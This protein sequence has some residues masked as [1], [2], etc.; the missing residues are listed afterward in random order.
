MV[1]ELRRG[2][3]QHG[4]VLANGGVLTY[5]HALC[6]STRPR[7]DGSPYPDKN[8]LARYV[9]DIP[10]PIITAEAEGEA[11]IE[12]NPTSNLSALCKDYTDLDRADLYSR[13]QP[14]RHSFKRVRRGPAD[15]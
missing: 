1:R 11:I 13:I 10:V 6:L 14:Q 3:S 15:E 12:V 4:L 2:S 5:Q 9:T 8:P 7:K